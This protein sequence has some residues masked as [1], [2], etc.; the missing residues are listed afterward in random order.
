MMA[1]YERHMCLR[2]GLYTSIRTT[3]VQDE[4]WRQLSNKGPLDSHCMFVPAAFII[5][6]YTASQLSFMIP[7]LT[8]LF[9]KELNSDNWNRALC[10]MFFVSARW[11]QNGHCLNVLRR[12]L[13]CNAGKCEISATLLNFAAFVRIFLKNF[14]VLGSSTCSFSSL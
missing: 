11:E 14:I 7:R 13:L 1:K 5:L 8:L 6:K 2:R 3:T 9:C 12:R 4:P 10:E